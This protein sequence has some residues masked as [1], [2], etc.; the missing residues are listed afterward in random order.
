MTCSKIPYSQE[1]GI[2]FKEQGKLAQEQG[3]LMPDEVFGTHRLF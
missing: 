2:I 3:N 1:Q